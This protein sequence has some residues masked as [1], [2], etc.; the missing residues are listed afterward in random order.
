LGN[1]TFTTAY[2]Y[3]ISHP[4]QALGPTG[5]SY[6]AGVTAIAGG[7]EHSLALKSDGTVWD[8]GENS[9]G[10][11]GNG[12]FT[13]A[14][15]DGNNHPVQ[16]IDPSDPSGFL[17]HVSAIA[18]GFGHSLAL[19]SDGTVWAWGYN[20]SGQLGNGTVNPA[21]PWGISHPVQV[22]DSS[23]PSGF[24]T[25]V[26]AIAAGDL[27]SLALKS[28]GTV[29]A[30]GENYYGELGNGQF[31]T[32]SFSGISHPVQVIDPGDVSGFL[33]HVI[34]IAAGGGFS[35]ALNSDGSVR[36]WG[37]NK[38][39]DLGI[40]TTT[41]TDP[42]GISHPVQVIDPSD[43]SGYLA[44]VIAFSAGSGHSLALK[45][46]G[47][48]W[49]WGY[50]AGGQLGNGTFT[51]TSPFCI[52]HPVQVIDPSDSSGFLT[53]VSAISAGGSHSLALKSDGT[54]RTWGDNFYGELGIGTFTISDPYGSSHPV[55]VVDPNN[56]S[57]PLTNVT[58]IAAG[59]DHSLAIISSGDLFD[60]NTDGYPDLL[61]QNIANGTASYWLM[62]GTSII[63]LGNF[64]HPYGPNWNLVGTA[65]LN[66]DGHPD[67]LWQNSVTRTASYWLMNGTTLIGLGN[68]PHPYGPDWNLV[69]AADLNGDGHPDLLW[70]NTANGTASYWLMNGTS[71]IGL[72]NFPHPYGANWNLVGAADLNGD[73]HPDLLWQNTVT[74]TVSYWLMNGTSI[75][76]L[77][78]FALKVA[79]NEKLIGTADLNGDGHPDLLWQNTVTRTASYWL[80]D[81]TT[82]L[83]QGNF[84]HPYGPDWNLVG[85]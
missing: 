21:S 68:F 73:G 84:P 6:L 60:L 24:L 50:N 70:Q 75:I 30:W 77:G 79:P 74:G 54:V 22:I 34:A 41:T 81:G 25:H 43:P 71:I 35:L 3:G 47:T 49:A 63:G 15:P 9:Y 39:G 17:T 5:T 8:W 72:G 23:D 67:L 61:W 80:L 10:Q 19:K 46:D 18:A 13:T 4:V 32:T 28:D 20:I 55:Q 66:G 44:H 33:T 11:L 37:F 85:P 40:G 16:V 36:A 65:D 26:T 51:N 82:I 58:A 31:T 57:Q 56:P 78:N 1:G 83:S 38:S 62:N 69:G 12:T 48:V 29:W 59:G 45:S 52:S 7:E 14:W 42:E 2:P 27:H 64:P 76:G 53:H